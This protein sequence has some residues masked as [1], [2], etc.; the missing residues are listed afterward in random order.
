[1]AFLL[2]NVAGIAICDFGAL[3]S[4]SLWHQAV[5]S[6]NPALFAHGVFSLGSKCHGAQEF[7]ETTS[8]TTSLNAADYR[9]CVAEA[10][11]L[12]D[13]LITV[14]DTLHAM[15]KLSYQRPWAPNSAFGFT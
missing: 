6:P 2:V 7:L 4:T 10:T 9:T 5:K 3:S 8:Q 11:V 13:H 14:V 12:S 15:S 1:M